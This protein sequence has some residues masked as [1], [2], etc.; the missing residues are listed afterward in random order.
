MVSQMTTGGSTN[1]RKIPVSNDSESTTETQPQSSTPM[2]TPE[3]KQYYKRLRYRSFTKK[4]RSKPENHRKYLAYL[5]K[6]RSNNQE[7]IKEYRKRYSARKKMMA[8]I[9]SVDSA[10]KVNWGSRSRMKAEVTDAPT[11]ISKSE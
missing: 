6:W 1:N 8:I 5:A 11:S 4:W 2:L 9:E 7:H 3:L 10:N